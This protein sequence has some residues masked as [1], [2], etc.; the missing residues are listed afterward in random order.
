MFFAYTIQLEQVLEKRFIYNSQK[1]KSTPFLC[2]I[3]KHK[4]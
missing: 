4:K 2:L 3:F 1:S